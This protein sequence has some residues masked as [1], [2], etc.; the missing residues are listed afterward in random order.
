M[1]WYREDADRASL[2]TIRP[3]AHR[4]K[5]PGM[6]IT[7]WIVLGLGAAPLSRAQAYP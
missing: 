6:S 2:A 3:F 1:A 7:V 4:S 5:E